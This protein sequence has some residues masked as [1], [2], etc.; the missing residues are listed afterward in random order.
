VLGFSTKDKFNGVSSSKVSCMTRKPE[1]VYKTTYTL[2][3][4][5]SC[6]IVIL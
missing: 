3:D 2:G 5:F 4:L 1:T 6:H